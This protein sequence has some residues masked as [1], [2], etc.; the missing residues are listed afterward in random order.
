METRRSTASAMLVYALIAVG[1]AGVGAIA[2]TS[3]L[4]HATGPVIAPADPAATAS[5]QPGAVANLAFAVDGADSQRPLRDDFRP[6]AWPLADGGYLKQSAG[7]DADGNRCRISRIGADGEVLWRQHLASACVVYTVD[8]A[9]NAWIG[10]DAL[11]RL[12]ANGSARRIEDLRR[13]VP[14]PAAFE[15]REPAV[16]RVSRK[17]TP[18]ASR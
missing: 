14:T 15:T 18:S 16:L 10:S 1:G 5:A 2:A 4:R 11:Y 7:R 13:V 12:D 6:A 3:W 8:G 17:E 9:G